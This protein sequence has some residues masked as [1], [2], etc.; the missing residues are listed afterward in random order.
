MQNKDH[1]ITTSLLCF[2]AKESFKNEAIKIIWEK[3]LP[4]T[5]NYFIT[6]LMENSD[7]DLVSL[8][9][10]GSMKKEFFGDPGKTKFKY[11]QLG[12]AQVDKDGN[13]FK[14]HVLKTLDASMWGRST[15]G[16]KIIMYNQ[17]EIHFS[18]TSSVISETANKDAYILCTRMQYGVWKYHTDKSSNDN[19]YGTRESVDDNKYSM[20]SNQPTFV[21]LDK[22]TLMP[23]SFDFIETTY[24]TEKGHDANHFGPGR[25]LHLYFPITDFWYDEIENKY[26]ITEFYSRLNR[27]TKVT[28][29]VTYYWSFDITTID[30]WKGVNVANSRLKK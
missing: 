2:N 10:T 6:D 5:K 3:E 16:G 13:N 7:G 30:G 15:N 28:K 12:I 14:S 29:K 24:D 22:E 17:R 23:T 26:M 8:Y 18:P 9:Q 4:L 25:P 27:K 20:Y 1:R 21:Y 19:G 11:V